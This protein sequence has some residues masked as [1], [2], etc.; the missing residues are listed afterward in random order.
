MS[1]LAFESNKGV[2]AGD[3]PR[4][5]ILRWFLKLK[6]DSGKKVPCCSSV[7]REIVGSGSSHFL[8]TIRHT[9]GVKCGTRFGKSMIWIRIW[10]GFYVIV[11]N[12]ASGEEK[13]L[14]VGDPLIFSLH[15]FKEVKF[16]THKYRSELEI[17]FSLPY[18]LIVKLSLKCTS[19]IS[20]HRYFQVSILWPALRIRANNWLSALMKNFIAS[21]LRGN[22]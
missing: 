15:S 1:V 18:A 4:S 16:E 14:W 5:S 2:R 6:A 22:W 21:L 19:I 11:A 17:L 9:S 12:S 10:Y 3:A 20:L 13:W 8:G 7:W